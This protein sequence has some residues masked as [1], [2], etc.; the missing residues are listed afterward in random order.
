MVT[1]CQSFESCSLTYT[2]IFD[3]RRTNQIW[4]VEEDKI[5]K[6]DRPIP[7]GLVSIEGAKVRLA[8]SSVLYIVF[9]Y[10]MAGW[11]PGAL[12]AVMWLT[13]CAIYELGDWHRNPFLKSFW[14]APGAWLQ[15]AI[16]QSLILEANAGDTAGLPAQPWSYAWGPAICIFVTSLAHI[17]DFRDIEGDS[18]VGRITLPILIGD[19]PARWVTVPALFA[20][21]KMMTFVGRAC[22]GA[23][24]TVPYE[25]AVVEWLS[26]AC[27]IWTA[28]RLIAYRSP[29]EDQKTYMSFCAVYCIQM[30]YSGVCTGAASWGRV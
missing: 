3:S 24:Q 28:F 4:G 30:L 29:A 9:A 19:A 1:L 15:L 18:A 26:L 16:T 6:P 17:Q 25:V 22:L 13:L 14:N 8:V 23:A 12:G 5:N 21:V 11:W 2:D 10:L 7:S 20:N 27:A